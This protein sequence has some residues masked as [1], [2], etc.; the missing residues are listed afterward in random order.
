MARRSLDLEP[1][2]ITLTPHAA[3]GWPS[4][5][6]ADHQQLRIGP[7]AEQPRPGLR[8]GNGVAVELR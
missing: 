4:V 8:C 2:H 5:M 6:G 3:G 1:E 7:L